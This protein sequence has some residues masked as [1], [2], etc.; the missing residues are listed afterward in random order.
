MQPGIL[1]ENINRLC[2]LS[3]KHSPELKKQNK[4]EWSNRSKCSQIRS[5]WRHPDLTTRRWAGIILLMLIW[6]FLMDSYCLK[7]KTKNKITLSCGCISSSVLLKNRSFS[8]ACWS[9]CS[10]E[11]CGNVQ[12]YYRYKL[13]HLCKIHGAQAPVVEALQ[14][15]K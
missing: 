11:I 5:W 4:T 6:M 10:S 7:K 8:Q 2:L 12:K 13:K 14:D 3:L 1:Y 15:T 9:F